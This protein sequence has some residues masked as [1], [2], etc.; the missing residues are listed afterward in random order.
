M[1][2]VFTFVS[3]RFDFG[4]KNDHLSYSYKSQNKKSTVIIYGRNGGGMLLM[5]K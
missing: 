1:I 3:V 4:T 2:V 5:L